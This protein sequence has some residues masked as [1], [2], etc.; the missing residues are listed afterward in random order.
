ME[1]ESKNLQPFLDDNFVIFQENDIIGMKKLPA[2]GS[3][4]FTV[5]D[6]KIVQIETRQKEK[7]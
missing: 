4:I 1:K 7:I 6:S 2:Y 5:Q 3:L